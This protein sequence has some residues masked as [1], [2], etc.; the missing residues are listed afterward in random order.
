M[1]PGWKEEVVPFTDDKCLKETC[2]TDNML[3]LSPCSWPCGF[4][5]LRPK[6]RITT[7]PAK[8][9]YFCAVCKPP[10]GQKMSQ[11]AWGGAREK[12][13]R[14]VLFTV[15]ILGHLRVSLSGLALHCQTLSFQLN[16][17]IMWTRQAYLEQWALSTGERLY[18]CCVCF[19][20]VTLML[21][22]YE[23]S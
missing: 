7:S 4:L 9:R 5:M 21:L 17:I 12:W 14:F 10:V 2:W 20:I 13:D 18:Q 23:R 1:S 11:L 19:S 22:T 16:L 8:C 3:F 6:K 15:S